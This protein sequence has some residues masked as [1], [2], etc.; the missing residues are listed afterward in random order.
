VT[1]P[2]IFPDTAIGFSPWVRLSEISGGIGTAVV[3]LT[4]DIQPG[5]YVELGG[6]AQVLHSL[7][8]YLIAG[9]NF[10]VDGRFYQSVE[11]TPSTDRRKDVALSPGVQL[12]VPHFL[13]YQNDLRFGYQY[14]WNHSNV[15]TATYKDHLVSITFV[16]RF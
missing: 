15:S 3:P 9:A 12:V 2:E 4:T 11:V 8:D 16:T 10:S 14:T 13:A 5:D 1:L 7:T 6:R